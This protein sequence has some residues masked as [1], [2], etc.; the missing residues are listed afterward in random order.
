MSDTFLRASSR[1]AEDG[2]SR[3]A[4]PPHVGAVGIEAFESSGPPI[5][6]GKKVLSIRNYPL[7]ADLVG[8][9]IIV[10]AIPDAIYSCGY[11]LPDA[12]EAGSGTF[13]CAGVVS[14]SSCV[15]ARTT[16]SVPFTHHCSL[17]RYRT[18]RSCTS[19]SFSAVAISA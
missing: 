14:L 9:P 4:A 17:H 12:L 5:F 11:V 2:A 10:L 15:H 3:H 19:L 18:V 8:K 13:R 6:A 1:R 7:P 16:V